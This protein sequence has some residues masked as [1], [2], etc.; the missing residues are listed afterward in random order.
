LD[1]W[2]AAAFEVTFFGSTCES[3]LPA[4]VFDFA[5]VAGLE[6]TDDALGATFGLVTLFCTAG[7]LE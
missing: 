4:P 3:A 6:S 2:V 5:L 1:A 7:S